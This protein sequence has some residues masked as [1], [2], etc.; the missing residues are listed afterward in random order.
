MGS[1]RRQTLQILE[2]TPCSHVELIV[3]SHPKFICQTQEIS[4][5][6]TWATT[7][8]TFEFQSNFKCKQKKE[9]RA[10]KSTYILFKW[11]PSMYSERYANKNKLVTFLIPEVRKRDMGWCTNVRM[12]MWVQTKGAFLFEFSHP[13]KRR[14]TNAEHTKIQSN[15]KS[16]Y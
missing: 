15:S 2:L 7:K 1:E 4:G 9:R 14:N 5:S 6:H 8:E 12:R 3:D 11:K 13:L 10:L 16:Q